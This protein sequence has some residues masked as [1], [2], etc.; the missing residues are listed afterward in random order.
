MSHFFIEPHQIEGEKVFIL[1]EDYN[2]IKNVLRMKIGEE[3]TISANNDLI[4]TAK[5]ESFQDSKVE[6]LI[7]DCN[8]GRAELP[9]DI[10]LFQ[11]LPKKDKMELIIEK[12]VELGVKEVVPVLMK[13]T[14]VKIEDEKKEAKKLERWRTIALTAAKQS[15]RDRVPTV[16]PF[17]SFKEAIE[18]ASALEFN[19]IPYENERGMEKTREVIR[20]TRDKK[21][22]GIFIGPEGG[23][24]EEELAMAEGIGAKKISLGN[25]ILRTETAGLAILSVLSFWLEA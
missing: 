25:R 24:T 23:I 7:T 9:V 2:H 4:Y 10:I 12:A 1:G 19:L 6:C 3:L 8:G 5:I 14:I 17:V 16:S 15:G 22:I 21:T 11:G 20:D 18:R 13:R